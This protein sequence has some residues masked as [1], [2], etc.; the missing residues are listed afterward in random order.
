MNMK[1]S[2]LSMKTPTNSKVDLKAA[3]EF[4]YDVACLFGR[5][6]LMSAPHWMQEKSKYSRFT[7]FQDHRQLPEPFLESH[8]VF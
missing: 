8:T 6:S 3:S 4:C 2:F 5:F 7:R 1:I